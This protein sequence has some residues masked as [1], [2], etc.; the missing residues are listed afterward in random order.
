MLVGLVRLRTVETP[1]RELDR[2]DSVSQYRT[3]MGEEL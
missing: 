2:P 3:Y 1:V